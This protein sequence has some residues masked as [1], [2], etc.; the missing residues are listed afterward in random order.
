MV[1]F[2]Q[3]VCLQALR[4]E[5]LV[6]NEPLCSSPGG[7]AEELLLLLQDRKPAPLPAPRASE[8]LLQLL[9]LHTISTCFSCLVE[10]EEKD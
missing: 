5:Q 9:L 2:T 7:P 3:S 10:E 6:H 1:S 8:L 4:V